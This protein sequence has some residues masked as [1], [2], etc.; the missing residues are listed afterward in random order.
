MPI[1]D[2]ELCNCGNSGYITRMVLDIYR[3][4]HFEV[5]ISTP[6]LDLRSK[7]QQIL[8]LARTRSIWH[9]QPVGTKIRA[10][11]VGFSEALDVKPVR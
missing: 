1:K 4:F 3:V 2:S 11:R 5:S 6:R 9:F 10:M 8:T 7:F